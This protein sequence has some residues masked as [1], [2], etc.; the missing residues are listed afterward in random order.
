MK[1]SEHGDDDSG[2][3]EEAGNIRMANERDWRCLSS[4]TFILLVASGEAAS[5]GLS[6]LISC[7]EY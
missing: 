1:L 2:T 6:W 4:D 7:L 3:S 5:L